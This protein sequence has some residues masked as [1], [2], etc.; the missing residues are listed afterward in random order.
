MCGGIQADR[1]ALM[2]GLDVDFQ[3]VPFRGSTTGSTPSTTRSS[4][5]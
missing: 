4:T 2:A 5:P 3:M 1:L